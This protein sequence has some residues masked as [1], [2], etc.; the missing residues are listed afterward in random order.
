MV[1]F[2]LCSV[3]SRK[4]DFFFIHSDW[5]R[6]AVGKFPTLS[7]GNRNLQSKPPP[8]F[9]VLH[10]HL[11]ASFTSKIT[12]SSTESSFSVIETLKITNAMIGCDEDSITLEYLVDLIGFQRKNI[13]HI[14]QSSI[15]DYAKALSNGTIEAA[16]FLAPNALDFLAKYSKGF[17]AQNAIC[18]V[19]PWDSPFASDCSDR[20]CS[21][22]DG[23]IKK[24]IGPGPFSGLFILSGGA[25]AIAVLI[26]VIPMMKRR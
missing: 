25:S 21:T 13:K 9:M 24:G 20:S 19:V 12:S 22:I 26:T 4:M 7:L 6:S 15:D 17:S 16:F 18:N 2:R 3:H 11:E 5:E 23:S 8:S 14:A 10:M 1:R